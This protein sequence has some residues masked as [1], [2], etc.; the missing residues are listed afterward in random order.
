MILL[1][2]LRYGIQYVQFIKIIE[3][4]INVNWILSLVIQ[5]QLLV[6]IMS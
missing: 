1:V 2:I 3:G 6:M 5:I 4:Y